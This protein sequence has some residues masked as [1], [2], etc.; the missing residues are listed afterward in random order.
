MRIAIINL[1]AGGMSGGYK[2][3]LANVLPLMAK[4]KN[5]D[6]IL[7]ASPPSLNVGGWLA[8][9]DKVVFIDCKPFSYIPFRH[10]RALEQALDK[11]LPDVIYI[12]LERYFRYKDIPTVTMIRNMEPLVSLPE[13]NPISE[14]IKN[15]LRA[16]NARK[17]VEQADRVIAVSDFVRDFMI[18][19]WG[20]AG[21]KISMIY[22][23]NDTSLKVNVNKP[24]VIPDNWAGNFLFTAGSIRPSRGL[25]DILE[26]MPI[27]MSDNN[28]IKGLVVAGDTN[29]NM[30]NYRRNLQ[31]WVK[32]NNLTDYICW[33]G[34]MNEDEMSWCY[35]NCSG[36][37]MTSRVESF[38]Q[39]ALESMTHGCLC[40]SA[41][42]PCLP[43]IFGDEATYYP[44]RD[45]KALAETI[46][47]ILAWDE[48]QRKIMSEKA[49][50]RAT[51]FSW[52]ICAESTVAELARVASR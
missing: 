42:N 3:Y 10:D 4:N 34:K 35:R 21:E 48:N 39:I 32:S 38:G 8:E 20:L 12:P 2:K 14:L 47:T 33:A 9:L 31:N 5:V 11:F 18:K 37:V 29:P 40:V 27:I 22:H 45:G 50:K 26:A 24:D 1:T 51:K 52:D 36:F 43:E 16:R 25:G 49:R 23:G 30:I 15:W 28:E 17:A 44:P 13:R 19:K 46:T 41:D 6:Q 7:C